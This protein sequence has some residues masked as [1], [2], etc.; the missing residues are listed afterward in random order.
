MLFLGST[1][2]QRVP[3]KLGK[4]KVRKLPAGKYTC[5]AVSKN[6]YS[7]WDDECEVTPGGSLAKTVSLSPILNPGQARIVLQWGKKPKDLDSFLSTPKLDRAVSDRASHRN[8]RRRSSQKRSRQCAVSYKKKHCL[9]GSARLD[10]DQRKGLGP[11]TVT[12]DSWVPGEYVYKVNHYGAR[13]KSEELKK[14]HA[15]V[16]VYTQDYVKVFEVGRQGAVDGDDWYVFSVDGSTRKVAE[17]T[18]ASCKK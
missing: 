6:F 3:V 15:E 13:G 16:A 4:F 12:L 9:G 8:W 17:C 11:E 18:L 2:V 1:F 10:V 7:Y 5:A 14:S